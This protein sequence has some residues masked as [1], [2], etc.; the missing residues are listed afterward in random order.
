MKKRICFIILLL[1]LSLHCLYAKDIKKIGVIIFAQPFYK[2]YEGFKDGLQKLGYE[3]GKNVIYY[4]K[5][6]N[7]NISEVK[8]SLEYFKSK[9]VDLI[10]TTTTFV[11]L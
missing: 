10:L 5:N 4:V 1:S 2:A 8:N 7:G 6:I 11:I 9:D 3:E